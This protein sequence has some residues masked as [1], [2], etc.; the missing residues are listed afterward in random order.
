MAMK[1]LLKEDDIKKALN[2]FKAVDSFDHKKFF[3]VVGLKALSADNVKLV[4]KALDVDASGFIEEEELKF[5]LKGFSA[6][7][8]DLTDKETKAFLTAADKDGD[9]KI[10]IDEFEAL[11]HE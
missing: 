9:G 5:V 7:G 4:F 3:D 1:N 11:V 6:D 2:Q 8:R 10:G